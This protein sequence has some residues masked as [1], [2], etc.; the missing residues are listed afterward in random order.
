M[1]AVLTVLRYSLRTLPLPALYA[2]VAG[3]GARLLV[4]DRWPT[5][6]LQLAGVSVG[7]AGATV[8]RLF[9][10]PAAD[11]V[12][13]LSRPMWWRTVARLL[14]AALLALAWVLAVSLVDT[15]GVGRRDVIAVQG[16]AVIVVVAGVTTALRRRGHAAPGLAVGSAVLLVLTA[17][18][19]INPLDR[20]LP[21]FPYGAAGDWDGSRW[22]W[23]TS[24][25]AAAVALVVSCVEGRRLGQ[26]LAG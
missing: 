15:G 20:W 10:E 16:V 5:S 25:A 17:L 11:V 13:T 23:S 4:V 19:L 6:T 2:G 9:D 8:S 26:R 14:S 22:L 12:D 18:V 7:V 1:T 24:A 21:V 3:A